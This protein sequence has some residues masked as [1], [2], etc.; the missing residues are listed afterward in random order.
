[1]LQSPPEHP[2]QEDDDVDDSISI[3]LST[4][5]EDF[6]F[7]TIGFDIALFTSDEPHFGQFASSSFL[8]TL[9]SKV[10][11]FLQLLHLYS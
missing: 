8:S 6:C 1:V 4:L 10:N 2:A 3:E 11:K 9:L 5:F 7:E